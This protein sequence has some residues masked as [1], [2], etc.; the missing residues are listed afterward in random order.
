MKTFLGDDGG[1]VAVGRPD[2]SLLPTA[3]EEQEREHGGETREEASGS[4]H[5]RFSG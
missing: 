4:F 2:D 3:G 1:M 5:S